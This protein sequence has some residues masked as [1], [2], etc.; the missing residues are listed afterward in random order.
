MNVKHTE[1]L[2]ARLK[3]LALSPAFAVDIHHLNKQQR[4]DYAYDLFTV[5]AE[6]AQLGVAD[7][8]DDATALLTLMESFCIT[9]Y[10]ALCPMLACHYNLCL[11]TILQLAGP[12]REALAPVIEALL[13]LR[14]HGLY[15]VSELACGNNAMSLKT[16]ARFDP[17]TQ[18]FILHTPSPDACKFMPYL[19]QPGQPKL[20]VVMARL[21]LDE[22]DC[23]VHPFVVECRDASGNLAPGIH[24]SGPSMLDLPYVHGVDHSIIAFDHVRVPRTHFLGAAFNQ[25][26]DDGR[27]FTTLRDHREIFFQSLC[28]VEWGKIFLTA[29]LVSGIKV[30]LAQAFHYARQRPLSVHTGRT[31]TLQENAYHRREL[32]RAYVRGL[33]ALALYDA[34]SQ[35]CLAPGLKP[36]EL[37]IL[38]G[39]V[40]AVSV[41]LA[42]DTLACCMARCGAQGKFLRNYISASLSQCDLVST[43]EGDSVPLMMK[44]AKD[45]L[46]VP[47]TPLDKGVV[48]PLMRLERQV[49]DTLNNAMASAT[50]KMDAWNRHSPQARDLT[51]F[52]GCRLACQAL[53]FR[54]DIQQAMVSLVILENAGKFCAA[55][56]IDNQQLATLG[57]EVDDQLDAIYQQHGASVTDEFDM[58][59]ELAASPLGRDDL[60][61]AWLEKVGFSALFG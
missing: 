50:D 27:F 23:G 13:A 41:E 60:A 34:I 58:H 45:L 48:Q 35:R 33:A 52:T 53:E 24:A 12:H 38:A 46:G 32:S 5:L 28:R 31:I 20:A 11:G 47:D 21:I 42:R 4:F 61:E 37:A 2:A 19:S 40:K 17:A 30:S 54:P 26:T 25:I 59:A 29:S 39:I 22:G 1:P 14:T 3:A 56:L 57:A 8:L 44:V 51:W 6:E 9:R 15:L 16:E 36:Q 7:I 55:G 49:K 10:A 18:A 43:A